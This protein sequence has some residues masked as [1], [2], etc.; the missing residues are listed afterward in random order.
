MNELIGTL[1]NTDNRDPPKDERERI[2]ESLQNNINTSLDSVSNI[3]SDID[4][5]ISDF[6]KLIE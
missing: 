2:M 1:Q 3:D 6:D 4:I 5:D